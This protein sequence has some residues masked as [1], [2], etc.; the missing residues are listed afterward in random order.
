MRT[1]AFIQLDRLD[2]R[3]QAA[4][5]IAGLNAPRAQVA[6]K[7]FYDS[8]GSRLYEAITETPEYYPTR[9]EAA[10]F[11]AHG[12]AIARAALAETGAAPTLVLCP[13]GT[14]APG[15]AEAATLP[16]RAHSD[17]VVVVV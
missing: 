16:R 10:I 9:T 13:S 14:A 1:P 12:P 11:A 15:R 6:P 17:A 8:L 5:A 3:A 7:F 4:E 2:D